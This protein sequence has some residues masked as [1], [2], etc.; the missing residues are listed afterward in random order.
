MSTPLRA[1]MVED[2]ENDALLAVRELRRGGYDVTWERVETA[3]T[4][5]AALDRQPWDIVISDYK[6][7]RFT[8]LDALNLLRAGAVDMPFIL[9]SGTIGEDVAVAA[10]KA[11]AHDY[12]IKGNLARLVPA[13]ERELR[14]AAERRNRQRAEA[15]LKTEQALL[16]NLL[17]TSPDHIYFKD[18]QSRFI[19]INDKMAQSFGLRSPGEAVG[20]SDFDFFT[21]EHAR[22]AYDDEQRLISTGQPIIGI[23]E[24]ETWPD[25]RV[26]WVST[27]KV[28]LHDADGSFTGLV[29]ISRDITE[30]K[31]AEEAL[32]QSEEQFRAMF[33]LASVGVAQADPRTGQWLRVNY[34]MCVISGYC[35]DELLRMTVS[36]ITYA[37]NRQSDWE[38]FERVVRGE[39][40]DCRLET[41]YVRKNGSLAWVNVNM[42]I[43][44]DSAGQPARTIATI[45]DITQRKR[46]EEA[47]IAS[48]VRYRRL[49]ESAK[50]GILILNAETGMIVDVNPF[51][52]E[53]LGF[54]REEFLGKKVWEL[55]PFKDIVANQDN[56]AKLCQK[57][58]IRYED[59]S[60]QTADGRRIPVEFVSNFYMVNHHKVILCNIR[61]IT[62]R[63]KS[64]DRVREQAALLDTA[65]DAIYVRTLDRTIT[66]WN[67]GAEQLYGWPAA[68]A[69]GRKE[70]DLFLP[71][72]AGLA[73]AEGVLLT[74]GGWA[75]EMH[76]SRKN[77]GIVTMFC[78]WS[79]V[80]DGEGNPRSVFAIHT[81]VTEKKQ[82]EAR[83]LRAQR[84]ES[85]GALASGIAHDLNNVLAPI[86][87]G[88]QLLQPLVA[89][90]RERHLVATIEASALR[91][92]GVV[93]QVLTFARGVGG[94]RVPLQ[95]KHLLSDMVLIAS[96]TF[97][98]N[99]RI[100]IDIARD[101]WPV[102]GD[103]TQIH[104][105]LMNLCV[106]ARDAM[107]SG[108]TL[109]L[110]A[111]N[112]TIDETFKTTG[113]G[114]SVWITPDPQPGPKSCLSVR[115]TGT[116]IS[117]EHL[118]K[119][120]EPFFT[121][122]APGKGTGLGLS[123]VLGIVQSHGGFVRV[124]SEEGQG[125]CFELY[126]PATARVQTPAD[127]PIDPKLLHGQGQLILVIDDEA[128]VR[129]LLSSVLEHY[130]YK[131]VTVAEGSEAVRIFSRQHAAIA[132]VISDMVM[133][134]MDG[135]A[136]VKALREIHPGVRLIGMSGLAEKISP[137][138][139]RCPWD[140][141]LFLTKPF[142]T[143]KLLIALH[144][145]LQ[146]P[147]EQ[148]AG[149]G[150]DG[151]TSKPAV[152]PPS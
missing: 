34:K 123:T 141:P 129:E 149:G 5:R 109:S 81:D 145:L 59:K 25:G 76:H 12:L 122:K 97:P 113:T 37:D 20:K 63:Q 82:L 86:V 87:M 108:G 131:V 42:T 31:Q 64:E 70:T 84:L 3:E 126:F 61:D 23:E 49:F 89:S 21:E 30:R 62:E 150:A 47:M 85:I 54:S 114:L 92:A 48:E 45:E 71:A 6:M 33:D 119:L 75:G 1:L 93:K 146:A 66:Y 91:G 95:L 78:R 72:T 69:V 115:D 135:P 121:T 22:Q 102:V 116:G 107:P 138:G 124:Q 43:I 105:A 29:G 143:E 112:V 132:A 106:N 101:L 104:Q 96:E 98:K 4:M 28:P 88:A 39:Q 151:S 67:H 139:S 8:G 90:E 144:E 103:A 130:G 55:E 133:P 80:R 19:R 73:E 111:A 128:I 65:N 137:T 24:K 79:L 68:K 117:P 32:R 35:V 83:F 125:S 77:G 46:T 120:F 140:L 136:L 40:L 57:E 16:T 17:K 15:S 26:T 36:E 41:R 94:E 99:I 9:V 50:D 18:R 147:A 148:P 10:M 11:G 53:I 110:R 134:G 152:S 7:P 13:V 60:L 51:L 74:Q 142:P 44:W 127:Q 27:T 14:D 56:F 118:D 58:Y 52:I 2:S 100:E 38:A